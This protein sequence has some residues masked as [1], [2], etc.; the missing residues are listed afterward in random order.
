MLICIDDF[1]DHSG[2]SRR[3]VLLHELYT[4][5]RHA[6]ISTITSVQRYRSLSPIIRVNA[7]GLVVFRLRNFKEYQAIEEENSV[8]VTKDDFKAI[9]D[10]ATAEPYSFLY[11]DM[12][13]KTVDSMF[14]LRFEQ[15]IVLTTAEEK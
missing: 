1:A 13:A 12:T 8:A 10:A 11:I 2:L 15:P 7:T 5:G 3:S 4:R 14:Y 6:G 9:Y